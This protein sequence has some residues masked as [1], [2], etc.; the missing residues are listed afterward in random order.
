MALY[1][2]AA[3]GSPN[4]ML[5][6]QTG[7]YS[8]SKGILGSLFFG[9]GGAAAGV[10]G[11]TQTVYKCPDCGQTLTYCMPADMMLKVEMALIDPAYPSKEWK[12]IKERY[13]NI[14]ETARDY[15][16]KRE[17]EQLPDISEDEFNSLAQDV[18]IYWGKFGCYFEH[19]EKKEQV[20]DIEAG[21]LPTAEEYSDVCA[22]V[23]KLVNQLPKFESRIKKLRPSIIHTLPLHEQTLDEDFIPT[24]LC[25]D[26]A[27]DYYERTGKAMPVKNETLGAY[28]YRNRHLLDLALSHAESY[29]SCPDNDLRNLDFDWLVFRLAEFISLFGCR[30]EYDLILDNEDGESFNKEFKYIFPKLIIKDGKCVVNEPVY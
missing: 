13:K 19:K 20:Y 15:A 26:I 14:G 30:D 1:R 2:C 8:Y 4:V 16:K 10:N 17:L 12:I 11:K 5:D 6:K 29:F 22:K 24:L 21:K 23:R 28:F 18:R 27:L 9:A 7:G 25:F 3:C